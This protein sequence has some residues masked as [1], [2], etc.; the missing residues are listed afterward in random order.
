MK[1]I[2]NWYFGNKRTH[3]VQTSHSDSL[4]AP[5]NATNLSTCQQ[6]SK[7]ITKRWCECPCPINVQIQVICRTPLVSIIQTFTLIFLFFLLLFRVST[8]A[9]CLISLSLF[10][11]CRHCCC[12]YKLSQLLRDFVATGQ[13]TESIYQTVV[14]LL[15]G[16]FLQSSNCQRL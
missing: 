16:T 5:L 2:K 8:A 11:C 15:S 9:G 1:N 13:V 4:P 7:L 3:R 6:W 12:H 14:K 10:R